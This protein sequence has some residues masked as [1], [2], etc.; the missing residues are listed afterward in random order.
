[1]S[2]KQAKRNRRIARQKGVEIAGSGKG[3]AIL[4]QG[5]LFPGQIRVSEASSFSGPLPPPA[6]LAEYEQ[7][8]PGLADRI[9]RMAEKEGDSRRALQSRA[10][11]LSEWGLASAFT[12]PMTALV[13][14]F[15]LV[16]N[17]KSAEGMAVIIGAVGSLLA[18]YFGRPGGRTEKGGEA[19]PGRSAAKT[20]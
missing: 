18:V 1:V 8:L 17:D 5:E 10:M 2:A 3:P 4:R 14:G 7:V 12:I 13:G 16:L 6:L 19:L 11:R 9:A 15:L 20:P